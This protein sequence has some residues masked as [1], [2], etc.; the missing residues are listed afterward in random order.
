MLTNEVGSNEVGVDHTGDTHPPAG[1]FLD[2]Q[3]VRQQRLPQPA[4]VGRNHQTEKTHRTHLID[5]GLRVGIGVLEIVGVGNYFL[6][7]ELPYRGNDF[8]LE[9]G[10]SESLSESSHMC[11]PPVTSRTVPVM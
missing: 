8:G 1:Q 2:A 4:V 11:R 9:F 5:D 10:Q 3:S 6:V 7:D